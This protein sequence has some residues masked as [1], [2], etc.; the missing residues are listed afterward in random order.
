MKKPSP[1][2][3]EYLEL[4]VRFK[5]LNKKCRTVDIAKELEIAPASVSEMFGKLE[6]KGFV[7]FKPYHGVELTKKGEKIGKGIL[8]KHRLHLFNLITEIGLNI[9][10]FVA[11]A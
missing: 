8:E 9:N 5:E 3:E 1:E 7:K 6:K 10:K 4:F 11:T 2:I